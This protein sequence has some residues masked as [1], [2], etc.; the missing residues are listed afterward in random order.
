MKKKD[1]TTKLDR[2]DFI[3]GSASA[4][5]IAGSG[6]SGCSDDTD[7]VK[8]AAAPDRAVAADAGT[9]RSAVE[10]ST[11][12]QGP[13]CENA[14][15]PLDPVQGPARVVEVHDPLATDGTIHDGARIKAM[16]IA[17]LKSLAGHEDIAESWKLLIP[18]FA[19]SMRIGIKLN[20]LSSYLYNSVPFLTSLVDTLVNNLGADAAK[21]LIWDRRGDELVRSKITETAMGTRVFGT[22][23]S[24]KDDSGPGYLST[25]E[26]IINRETRISR[27]L[28]DE[29]DITINIPLLKTHGVAGLTGAMKNTYGCIDNP[30]EF[31]SDL[32][33]S[34]P[35][36]Y[37]LDTIRNHFRLHINEALTAVTRG[38][39]ADPP[40]TVPS[41]LMLASDPLALDTHALALMN[42]LRGELPGV[43]EAKLGW[44]PEAARL[45]LGTQTLDSEVITIS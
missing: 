45:N 8:D 38:D 12:D 1:S 5:V 40:D 22:V 36:I 16:L 9:D 25:A 17:G 29:T 26:C 37:R 18:D 7:P 4:V 14:P 27:I 30:G 33:Y 10:A 39:T 42:T 43:P 6:L 34:L 20:C 41:R 11:P 28:T 21:I 3:V 23:T 44:L 35:A 24:T 32:N 13:S 31:H 2:R 19:P 15:Q